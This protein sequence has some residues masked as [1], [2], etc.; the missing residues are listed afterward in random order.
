MADKDEQIKTED[1]LLTGDLLNILREM[2]RNL[3]V[4]IPN[5]KVGFAGT[6]VTGIK[7]A[8][9]GIDWDNAKFI[10]VPEKNMQEIEMEPVRA[11]EY[12]EKAR[13]FAEKQMVQSMGENWDRKDH[14]NL[15]SFYGFMLMF[16]RD[17]FNLYHK[18]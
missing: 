17:L 11:K 14:I 9:K 18:Y 2:P 15:G 3:R 8:H 6:K 5:N 1:L 16:I 12:E 13:E 4:C 10:I 7:A